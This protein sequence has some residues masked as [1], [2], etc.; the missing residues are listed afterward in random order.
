VISDF[1][2]AS[3]WTSKRDQTFSEFRVG[4]LRDIRLFHNFD[5]GFQEISD[6]SQ[7][8]VGLLRDIRLFQN[9]DLG[10]QEISDFFITSRWTS[11]RYQTF[12]ELRV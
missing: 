11:K 1:F 4:L 5:L 6:F 7:L 10:F 2:R 3:L 12:S 9:F 8:R